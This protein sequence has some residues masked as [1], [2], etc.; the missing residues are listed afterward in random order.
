VGL[1][2]GISLAN[3]AHVRL[4][5]HRA[6]ILSLSAV[7]AIGVFQMVYF[8]KEQRRM[9]RLHDQIKRDAQ[10]LSAMPASE[11]PPSAPDKSRVQ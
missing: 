10:I 11:D 9:Q 5:P 6:G 1:S 7:A 8:L 4:G 3:L 2:C